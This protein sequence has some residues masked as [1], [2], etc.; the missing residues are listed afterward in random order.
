VINVVARWRHDPT[1]DVPG[2]VR[3]AVT[4]QLRTWDLRGIDEEDMALVLTELVTNAVEHARTPL[5]VTV[6]LLP[7]TGSADNGNGNGSGGP[8]VRIEVA[9][10]STAPPRPRPL[11]PW[12]ARGRGLQMIEA[13]A[14]G[15]GHILTATGKTVWAELAPARPDRPGTGDPPRRGAQ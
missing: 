10:G 13:L 11:D 2:R 14:T 15:W 4:G 7:T 1:S 6:G 8:M 3:R 12:A 5:T 9:D